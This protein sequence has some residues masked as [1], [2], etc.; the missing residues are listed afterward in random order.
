MKRIPLSGKH[1]AGRY[2]LV[3]D[4]DY[5]RVSQHRWHVQA[6]NGLDKP[7]A[8]T[9]ISKRLVYMHGFI[10]GQLGVDHRNRQTLDNQKHN[11][12]ESTPSKQGANRRSWSKSG[13]KGVTRNGNGW[14]ARIVVLRQPRYLGTFGTA[15]EA[16]HAY[17]DAAWEAFGEHAMLN[18]PDPF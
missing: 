12:R 4:E 18:Y 13:F 16:A 7:Y 15:E 8:A 5:E 3:D 10:M 6:P 2:A 9:W 1:G 14:A 17:D 11:L